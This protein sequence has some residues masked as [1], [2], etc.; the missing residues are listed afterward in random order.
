LYCTLNF[1]HED[2]LNKCSKQKQKTMNCAC[3]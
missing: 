1:K 3:P 2:G